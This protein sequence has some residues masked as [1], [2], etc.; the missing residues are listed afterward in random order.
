MLKR[1]ESLVEKILWV[2]IFDSVYFTYAGPL[3]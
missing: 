1:A 2:I 3:L